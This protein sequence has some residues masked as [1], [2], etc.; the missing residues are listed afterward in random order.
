VLFS[1]AEQAMFIGV[2]A[3][4]EPDKEWPERILHISR[5][6]TA[7]EAL[8]QGGLIEIYQQYLRGG[9]S[10]LLADT[11]AYVAVSRRESWWRDENDE[12]RSATSDGENDTAS[13]YALALTELGSQALRSRG[14]DDLFAFL[15]H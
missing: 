15:R 8:L 3:N 13:I 1:A 4:W 11:E 14:G 12:D 5:L 2:L 6:A 9:T 10:R 7:T